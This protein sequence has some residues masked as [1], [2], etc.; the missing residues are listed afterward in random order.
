M[1][2]LQADPRRSTLAIA[3]I[4]AGSL[5]DVVRSVGVA[6]STAKTNPNHVYAKTGAT[7]RAELVRL[8]MGL[9]TTRSASPSD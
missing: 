1:Q 2:H 8:V 9:S 6:S 5:L 4:A 3:T 7:S